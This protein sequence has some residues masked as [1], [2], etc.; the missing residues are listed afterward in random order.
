MAKLKGKDL[1]R[2]IEKELI[3]M[4]DEGYESSPITQSSVANRL[5]KK[6]LISYRSTINTR[7]ELVEQFAEE[8]KSKVRGFLGD[9]VR[10][11][12]SGNKADL[13]SANARLRNEVKESKM[14]VHLNTKALLNIIKAV[15]TQTNVRNIERVLSPFLIRE[16]NQDLG[17]K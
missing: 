17:E 5:I 9:A 14:Q 2:E 4:L 13:I 11:A 15:R 3:L 10:G 6:G 1:D 16:L 12:S 8:Q 7:K